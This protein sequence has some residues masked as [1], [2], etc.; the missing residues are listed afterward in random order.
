MLGEASS[1]IAHEVKN[2]LNGLRVGLDVVIQGMRGEATA[3]AARHRRPATEVERL[4]SFTTELLTFSRASCRA[5]AVD[6]GAWSRRS[7]GCT[8]RGRPSRRRPRHRRGA[9]HRAGARRPVAAALVVTNL[10]VNALER[11]R[12]ARGAAGRPRRGRSQRLDG[13]GARVGQWTR[14]ARDLRRA[15]SSRS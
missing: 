10:V 12:P 13:A 4:S 1:L 3:P 7:P 6:L 11:S 15:C 8:P 2:A 14:R 9:R 5:G